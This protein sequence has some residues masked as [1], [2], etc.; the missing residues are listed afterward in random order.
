MIK[1]CE[2]CKKEFEHK[3]SNKK[4]CSN[5]CVQ[6]N[7]SIFQKTYKN[8]EEGRRKNSEAQ[9]IAQ[10]RP[11]V[12]EKQQKERKERANRPEVKEKFK[13]WSKEYHN[14][15]DVKA[16]TSEWTKNFFAKNPE[17]LETF[18]KRTKEYYN[19]EYLHDEKAKEKKSA[20]AKKMNNDPNY[21]KKKSNTFLN[22]WKDPEFAE[23]MLNSRHKYKEFIFPSGKIVKIQGYEDK[24]LKDLLEKYN[25]ND[26]FVGIKNIKDQIGEIYYNLNENIH[27]YL[28]DIYVKSI[29]TVFEV[30]SKYTYNQK[31]EINSLKENA[32]IEKG[33]NFKFLIY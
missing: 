14:R 33:F 9:K 13:K 31:V 30:K 22:K 19:N 16:I 7:K 4:F 15:E 29:N 28:P 18:H 26:I 11:D 25:E 10:N 32:C 17:F 8:S 2:L 6:K 5:E 3:N 12:K 21:K 23:F 24:A 27:Q 1:I 20:A